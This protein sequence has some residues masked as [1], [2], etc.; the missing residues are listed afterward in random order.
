M[1]NERLRKREALDREICQAYECRSV[2]YVLPEAVHRAKELTD[3]SD[4]QRRKQDVLTCEGSERKRRARNKLG[5]IHFSLM[6]T[7][8]SATAADTSDNDG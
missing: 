1:A 7:A 2:W 4:L 5:R 8:D 6:E 3:P